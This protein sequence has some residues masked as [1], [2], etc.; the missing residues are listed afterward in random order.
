VKAWL[1]AHGV[2]ASRLTSQGC[3]DT[4]PL[5]PN[6]TDENRFKNRRVELKRNNCRQ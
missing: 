2:A 6:T 3:G 5:V 1:I 4:R